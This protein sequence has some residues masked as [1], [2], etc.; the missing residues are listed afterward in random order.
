MMLLIRA[1]GSIGSSSGGSTTTSGGGSST[2]AATSSSSSS[3][4]HSHS[5]SHSHASSDAPSTPSE[6]DGDD[7][8]E[9][10]HAYRDA[11]ATY[12]N[13]YRPL[14][15]AATLSARL[16]DVAGACAY[17]ERLLNLTAPAS[18][19][20][21]AVNGSAATNCSAA[22]HA[23]DRRVELRAALAYVRSGGC[24]N[25]SAAASWMPGEYK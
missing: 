7:I 15:G 19:P 16:G 1:N 14:A 12:P 24:R 11:L 8:A 17:Y 3:D 21:F 10:L 25:A 4:R 18:L 23:P 2:I 22:S 13:R 9:A 6:D 5:H 20:I